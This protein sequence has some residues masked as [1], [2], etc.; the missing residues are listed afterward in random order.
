MSKMLIVTGGHLD[1]DWAKECLSDKKFAYCIAADSGLAYADR[2][3]L[4]ID[5]LLGDY[6]S[7]DANVLERYK[8]QVDFKVYPKEKDYTD[9][10]LAI[11]TAV[12]KGATDIYILGAT[13]NRMDH[14]LTNIGN[15]KAAFDCG[16]DCHIIDE[17]NYMYL[18]SEKTGIHVIGR[19]T[20][21]GRYVSLVPMSEEVVV[22][23][24]GFK[25]TLNEYCL[26][27]GLSICQSNEVAE[28]EAEI[29]IHKG[30][31]VIFETRD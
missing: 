7:V 29:I 31:A 5:F 9:T 8:K 19:D 15:M 18:I 17:N 16:V 23:L 21:Y 22:T 11:I 4:K 25:Y 1:I 27:Q 2:L 28:D 6:D 20:Q 24:K 10:H 14:T 13:G 3:G 30:L 12:K 26:R